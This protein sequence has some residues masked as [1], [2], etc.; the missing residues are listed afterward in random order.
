MHAAFTGRAQLLQMAA[1]KVFSNSIFSAC[2]PYF[3]PGYQF[4]EASFDPSLNGSD[5]TR[6]LVSTFS[7]HIFPPD[8]RFETSPLSNPISPQYVRYQNYGSEMV[9]K[10]SKIIPTNSADVNDGHLYQKKEFKIKTTKNDAWALERMFWIIRPFLCNRLLSS[11]KSV[12][13]SPAM[14]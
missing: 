2:T 9:L 5:L 12:C 4:Y 7:P 6:F 14:L 11:T 10:R 8:A 3:A 13:L 1:A